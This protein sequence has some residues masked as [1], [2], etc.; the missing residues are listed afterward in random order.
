[1]HAPSLDQ[2][3]ERL[4][5]SGLLT[6]AEV[7]A[8]LS[9]SAST[10]GSTTVE[11]LARSLVNSGKLTVWQA[12]QIYRG[13]LKSLVLGNYVLLDKLGQGG[14]GMVFKAEHRVMKRI[15]A[16]KTLSPEITKSPELVA[17]FRREVQVAARL[18]HPNIVTA[19]DAAQD[20]ETHYLVMQFVQGEDL[21]DRVRREG[22]LPLSA[23]LDVLTQAA[24]GLGYAHE[25]G[26][27]HRDIKPSNLLVD[28][29]GI[30]RVLDMGLARLEAIEETSSDLTGSGAVM[31]TIDY[32]SPE[33]AENTRQAD[34]RS[35]IYSLGCTLFYL[36]VGRPPF[37]GN[38]VVQRILAHRDAEIPSLREF[39]QEGT[40]DIN[41]LFQKM[42]AKQP[43]DRFQTMT[44]V[45]AAL[46]RIET[47]STGINGAVKTSVPSFQDFLISISPETIPAKSLR[48]DSPQPER[49][50]NKTS[51]PATVNAS[52]E[53]AS[54]PA[55]HENLKKKPVKY[56]NKQFI[57]G[58][59]VLFLIIILAAFS[60]RNRNGNNQNQVST[61]PHEQ[62]SESISQDLDKTSASIEPT[63]SDTTPN[64]TGLRFD[65]IDD[66]VAIPGLS[67]ND[68]SAVT[69]EVWI[70]PENDSST[71][72][73][74]MLMGSHWMTLYHAGADWGVG[75]LNSDDSLLIKTTSSVLP[76]KIVHLAGV[77]D[78]EESHLFIDGI[79]QQSDSYRFALQPTESG[80]YLG[81]APPSAMGQNAPDRYFQGIIHQVRV[82]TGAVYRETFMPDLELSETPSTL[83][84]FH[85]TQ[86]NG[87]SI[88][89]SSGQSLTGTIHGATWWND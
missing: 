18:D 48:A 38:T 87:S 30:V 74:V 43:A 88:R 46:K 32:M 67:L 19:F 62:S 2:F 24:T 25:Q 83:A 4:L 16:L 55:T 69:I 58:G 81:G 17:R 72:N 80:L 78:G 57:I 9:E 22:V 34:A 71:A 41:Q 89:D 68:E 42:V 85:L 56:A 66:Y 1:M 64:S 7:T 33:Q 79:W 86:G 10:D 82:S 39:C 27:I 60:T 84:V 50:K 44:E 29:N 11:S 26:V 61:V 3:R 51:Q 21:S 12:K 36:L 28:E 47:P 54:S 37:Q 35:D 70:T 14:M 77:W 52:R 15:V 53:Q 73:P 23:A 59:A 45:V 49:E 13:K 31:G 63:T 5:S 20:G 76:N 75:K 65:G 8:E 6:A 40:A